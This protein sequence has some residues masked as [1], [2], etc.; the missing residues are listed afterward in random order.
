MD[1]TQKALTNILQQQETDT[2]PFD[3]KSCQQDKSLHNLKTVL[4]R[5]F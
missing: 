1:D 3:S 4:S 2:V 5:Q